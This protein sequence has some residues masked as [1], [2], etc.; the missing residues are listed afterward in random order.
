VT[1]PTDGRQLYVTLWSWINATWQPNEYTYTACGR[2]KMLSPVPGS[3]LPG[4][5]TTFIWDAYPGETSYGL[6]VG[7]SPMS[8]DLYAAIETG[9][10]RMLALPIDGRTIYVTLWA[11]LN[12]AW[13]PYAYTF[14]AFGGP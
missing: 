8:Y 7:N 3:K 2:T 4:A 14:T 11:W 13:R 1:L 6:W 9:Q 10:S 5:S 12:G